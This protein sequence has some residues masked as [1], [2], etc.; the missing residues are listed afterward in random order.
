M[1]HPSDYYNDEPDVE[2]S[3]SAIEAEVVLPMVAITMDCN[4]TDAHT[5][6]LVAFV[7]ILVE[8]GLEESYA[9]QS[10]AFAPDRMIGIDLLFSFCKLTPACLQL[11]HG[12][13]D[14]VYS[15]PTRQF[16]MR[17]LDLGQQQMHVAHLDHVA[18]ILEKTKCGQYSIKKLQLDRLISANASLEEVKAT[19]NL[20]A[21]A[22]RASEA[23]SQD[24]PGRSLR[25][26][27]LISNPLSVQSVAAF[28]SALRYGCQI[29]TLAIGSVLEKMQ[30]ERE[31]LEVARL[32]PLLPAVHEAR[33]W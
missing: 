5:E 29:E 7:T 2:T 28:C 22:F 9:S 8:T 31:V 16:A 4:M 6:A 18:A 19:R 15:S 21:I 32:R 30:A 17:A 13:L 10:P 14:T 12:L 3:I 11:L 1:L 20:M 33:C 26:L 27:D 24:S 25:S 23:A